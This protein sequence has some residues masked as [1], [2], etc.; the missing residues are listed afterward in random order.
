MRSHF[1]IAALVCIAAL[2]ALGG[3]RSQSTPLSNPFLAPDRVPPPATRTPLPG[4]AQPYYPTDVVPGGAVPTTPPATT[5]APATTT[6]PSYTNPTAPLQTAPLQTTPLPT[7]PLPTTPPGGWNQPTTT[8]PYG[9]PMSGYRPMQTSPSDSVA[10]AITSDHQSLRFDGVPSSN[11]NDILQVAANQ[12]M[13][14]AAPY[15]YTPPI[16]SSS[17]GAVSQAQFAST[18]VPAAASDGFRPQGSGSTKGEETLSRPAGFQSPGVSQEEPGHFGY[19]ST[20]SWLRGQ[21]QY[22]PESGYWGLR[23]IALQGPADSYGGVAVIANPEVLA[24]VQP[25]EHLLVQ[26]FM[27]TQ[28][29]FDGTFLPLYTVEGIQR[30]R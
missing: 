15:I 1:R 12:Q 22:Y 14:S 29:N 10:V 16:V 21:L 24:G 3:C 17:P 4:T 13:A 26:G 18:N 8:T 23:Y 11:P 25:G 5:F 6:V 2:T 19:D 9:T 30:Q 28:D 27:E 20:Y 7:N